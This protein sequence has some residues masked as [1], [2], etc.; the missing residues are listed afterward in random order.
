MPYNNHAMRV[1]GGSSLSYPASL[2]IR[3]GWTGP[4]ANKWQLQIAPLALHGRDLRRASRRIAHP[5]AA[6]RCVLFDKNLWRVG[7]I[8]E[9]SL[10]AE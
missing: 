5:A 4:T 8:G 3:L 1:A 10:R 2:P 6:P 7:N 9:S